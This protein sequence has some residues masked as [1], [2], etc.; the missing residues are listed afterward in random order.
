M[1]GGVAYVWDDGWARKR[2]NLDLVE[3]Q[4][5]TK[6]DFVELRARVQRHVDLTGS[7]TAAALVAHWATGA[8]RFIKVLPKAVAAAQREAEA[9]A[10]AGTV[11]VDVTTTRRP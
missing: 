2:I 5:P 9:R 6:D 4:A 11:D 3:I 1:T 7:E 8:G 10:E